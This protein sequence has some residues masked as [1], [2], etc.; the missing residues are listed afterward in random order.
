MQL[1]GALAFRDVLA[2]PAIAGETA[3]VV[4]HRLAAE[5]E[6][7]PAAAFTQALHLEIPE[8]LVALELRAMLCPVG[9]GQVERGLVPALAAEVSFGIE[10]GLFPQRPR[11]EGEAE[12][13][14]LFPIPVARELVQA[15]Q[16]RLALAHDLFGLLA[17]H[18]LAD[19]AADHARCLQQPLLGL[20]HFAAVEREHADRL[21]PGQDRKED[22]SVQAHDAHGAF[23]HG[24]AVLVDVGDPQRLSRAPHLAH[25]SGPWSVGDVA[26]AR[27]KA[28][29]LRDGH[30]PGRAKAHQSGLVVRV[31]VSAALPAFG[32]AHA[33][34]R[35]YKA[36]RGAVRIGKGTGH[37][38]LEL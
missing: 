21:S 25:Q 3:G 17:L 4:E 32:L 33:P 5:R 14:V 28:L 24:A 34:D 2:D 27:E 8:R 11:H 26:R 30:A 12:L 1:V 20:A 22:G 15:A 7:D 35:R 10:P 31:E 38:V 6:P 18:E 29:D 23:L 16:A 19:L 36:G 9:L 37:R 13:A